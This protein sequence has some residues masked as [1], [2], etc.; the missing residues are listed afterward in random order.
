MNQALLSWR[1]GSI[2]SPAFQQYQNERLIQCLAAQPNV[3]FLHR[4][5]FQSNVS[6]VSRPNVDSSVLRSEPDD[7]AEQCLAHNAGVNVLAV[8]QTSGRYL[9]SGGGDS[10]LRLWDLECHP[11]RPD[12][13]A[14]CTYLPAASLTRTTPGSHTHALTSLSI[15]PFDP[16]PT[17]LLTTSFDKSLRLTAIT[18]SSLAPIHTFPFD[19][20]P[21]T[22][23]LSPIASASPLVAVGTAQA[24]VRLLD[25]RSGLATHSLPGHSGAIFSLAW[26]P[27]QEHVLASGSADGRVLFFDVRRANSTFASLDLDDA[28]GVLPP[29]HT[30]GY[31]GRE[32]LDW[33]VRA[34]SGP[35]TN[36]QWTPRGDKLVTTG[37]DQRIRVWDAATGRNELVH[38]GPRIRNERKGEYGPLLAPAGTGKEVLFWANDDGKGDIFMFDAKEGNM[39]S[40]LRTPGTNRAAAQ[41]KRI[42]PIGQMTSGGRINAMVWRV[43]A[44]SG[45]GLEMYSAHGDGKIRRWAGRPKDDEQEDIE[46]E[47]IVFGEET[48]EAANRKRKRKRDLVGGLVEGLTTRP[49]HV[50][51]S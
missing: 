44:D 9:L 29:D 13:G 34:H 11:L 14:S 24:H 28:I 1:L 3:R 43:N 30:P 15:Y 51:F 47:E 21:Y 38:F 4:K 7:F 6:A 37:H 8:D 36:V 16:S 39:L 2:S 17:T 48:G 33:N 31:G 22:H 23:A 19:Y 18:P 41:G 10:T 12:C 20:S 42:G 27:K 26:S 46:E 50:P 40:Q 32:A 45:A 49:V 25:L 5:E 35:V